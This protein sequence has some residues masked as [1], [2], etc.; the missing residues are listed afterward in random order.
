MSGS[1]LSKRYSLFMAGIICNAIGVAVTTRA[2]LG[3][4]PISSLP[5]VLSL[6]FPLSFG[7]FTFL[8][9]IF[10]VL[11]QV[12]LLK[13]DFK[14]IQY[15]QFAAV[16]VFSIFIDLTMLLLKYVQFGNYYVQI[17][18]LL[19]GCTLLGL[20][21][22]LEV[23]ANV[24]YI[25]GEGLVKALTM[26]LNR[27]FGYVKIAFDLTLVSSA[28]AV[29]WLCCNRIEGLREGTIIGAIIVGF[30]T[31]FFIKNLRPVKMWLYT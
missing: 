7:A 27:E 17:L 20:G 6:I 3:T 14:A 22:C 19:I 26:K 16:F 31:R 24:I 29:S 8:V 18:M 15:F 13:K 11:G 21:I 1:R 12:A 4:T 2:S 25:P 23:Y 5:Y 28:L 30:I 10:L 9:N